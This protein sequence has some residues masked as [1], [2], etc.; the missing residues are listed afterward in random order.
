MSDTA[1]AKYKYGKNSPKLSRA[2]QGHRLGDGHL[3]VLVVLIA[4]SELPHVGRN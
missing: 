1:D 2:P 3:E 4:L